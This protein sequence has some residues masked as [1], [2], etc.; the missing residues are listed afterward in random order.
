[1]WEAYLHACVPE[2]EPGER[3]KCAVGG[4]GETGLEP[5]L[6]WAEGLPGRVSVVTGRQMLG[7]GGGWRWRWHLPKFPSG[8]F[9]VFSG[10]GSEVFSCEWGGVV[11][12]VGTSSREEL[13][14]T[15]PRQVREG[16]QQRMWRLAPSADWAKSEGL[17]ARPQ[18]RRVSVRGAGTQARERRPQPERG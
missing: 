12:G 2:E 3:E 6:E 5:R 14:K 9:S 16:T 11:G 8:G 1:M 13:L 15:F 7:E 4:G 17:A 18:G 10:E